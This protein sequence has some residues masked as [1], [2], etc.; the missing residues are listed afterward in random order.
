M[1]NK[2]TSWQSPLY[3]YHGLSTDE[4]PTDVPVNSIFTELDTGTSFYFSGGEWNEMPA[5]S[6]G[7]GGDS[8]E[9]GVE[10]FIVT[11]TYAND[12]WT[13]ET[14]IADIVSA[15]TDGQIVVCKC[16]VANI[17]VEFE[18][19]CAVANTLA[20]GDN[21]TD[22]VIF[23]GIVYTETPATALIM[24]HTDDETDIWDVVVSSLVNELPAYSA[25]EDGKV[26]GV[27][28]GDLAWVEQ[29]GGTETEAHVAADLG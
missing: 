27:S 12:A 22:F 6:G 5:V 2:V 15:Y 11:L 3:E 1:V 26:L 16:D 9:S 20:D 19:P 28:S 25:S 4:K 10:K 29:T 14:S 17:G 7:G 24:A 18:L 21:S 13:T 8:G 23:S